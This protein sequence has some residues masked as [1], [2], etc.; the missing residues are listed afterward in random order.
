[1][2][3]HSDRIA[4]LLILSVALA[5]AVPLWGPGIVNTRG[6]G[7]S[8][9]LLQR[10]H[11]M[12][13]NLR[14]GVF[15]VR[16]MPD[17]AYGL[18]YPF[19]SYYAALPYYIGG[20]LALTGLDL[21]TA[22]KLTQTLGFLAAAL[23]MYGW[24]RRRAG[25][26]AAALAAVAYTAAPFHLVNVYVRGDSL[27]EF[28]AFIFYP[29]ILW[30]LESRGVI[31]AALAYAGLL[32]THNISAF[33]FT[34]FVFLAI[35]MQ[36]GPEWLR[37]ALRGL[38]ALV[39]GLLLAAWF[40]APALAESRLVQL[41][42]V[43]QG[44]FHYVNHFRALNLV[45]NRFFFDYS[46]SADARTPF[47]MGLPQALGAALGA[48]WLLVR[49]FRRRLDR[50]GGFILLGLLFSTLMITPLSKPLWDHLPLLPMV[51]FPWRFLSV[52][53][54]F[55]ALAI[56]AP[57]AQ[58]PTPLSR[59]VA[60]SLAV[61]LFL[62]VLF[63]LR[64]DRLPIGPDEV[65]TERLLLYELFTGNIGT[66]IRHEYLYRAVVPRP[67]TSDALV[68]PDAPLRAIP[69]DDAS[70]E[71]VL[72]ERAPTRQV[73]RVVGTGGSI[74]F[75]LLYWP[76]W[77]ALVDG[78]PADVRPVEGSGYLSL[79]VPPGEHTV[80][81][82]L[83]RTPVRA[84]AEAASLTTAGGILATVGLSRARRRKQGTAVTSR[85]PILWGLLLLSFPLLPLIGEHLLCR[86]TFASSGHLDLTMDFIQMPYLHH[87]PR[88]VRFEGPAGRAWLYW[89]DLSD[90]TPTPGSLLTVTLKMDA[91]IPYT[92]V[93]ELVSPASVRYDLS[94]LAGATCASYLCPLNIPP[95]IPRG[96]Y[97][98]RLR[99]FGPDGELFA[100]TPSGEPRG[101]LYLAPIRVTCGLSLP[102]ETPI[103]APFGPA[104]RLYGAT[105]RPMAPDR[106]E[107]RLLWSSIRPVAANY[108][109]SLRLRD[110]EG[111]DV[112]VMDTQP[113]YGFLPT[114]MWR[115]GEAV[116]DRY[117]LT[118]PAGTP[119][120]EGY[121]LEVILYSVPTLTA[122][123]QAT[124]GPFSLPLE[125]PYEQ[126]G[127]PRRFSLPPLSHPL[128]VTFG[129]EIRLAGYELDRQA[130]ALRLTLWWQALTAP[131]ADY[132]V[133]VHLFGPESPVP[134]VQNDAPPRGGAYPTSWW[135]AGEVVDETVTLSLQDVPPGEYRLAVGLYRPGTGERLPA[136]AADGTPIPDN[137]PVL[138][139]VVHVGP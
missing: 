40:W 33:I 104:I 10:L 86:T 39:L 96:L 99:V 6:G 97:L 119:P 83:G 51:Q 27:S 76:G 100:R 38:V 107:V 43:T 111:R 114:S 82:Y 37:N 98:L 15:P 92:P 42:T 91:T 77:Q 26:P 56:A 48:G 94:P 125:N 13:A 53:A 90:L 64:P 59:F 87:N 120:G 80:V 74:A 70:M 31:W 116:T 44:Y 9:F 35:L 130:D 115:P 109:I 3:N 23:A 32:L 133:F 58:T 132:T 139:E 50:A 55:A 78:R 62:A 105:V 135:V 124:I 71:V 108:G 63:P 106:L 47:A 45:Q 30:A 134:I 12:T 69:L 110:A 20:L 4:I 138:P 61:L 14:A 49:L 22:V 137:R 16:W 67:F 54:L 25:P 88:G 46:I 17:A 81:L 112:V 122:Q 126:W 123:G 65:T 113:G 5:A 21:L 34:P 52:Q 128:G 127:K 118:L 36:P 57:F 79:D 131:R 8:P 73:W 2:N 136:F 19:F 129:G 41:E 93:L 60:L 103:L 11:Q 24:A 28:Y 66:T 89:Y 29:L 95:D 75:P 1:M 68:E 7:D 72:L 85:S 101:T 84:A 121:R 18:G 117:E 102:P